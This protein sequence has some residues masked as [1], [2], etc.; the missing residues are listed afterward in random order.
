ML[1]SSNT[2][3]QTST[4]QNGGSNGR[5]TSNVRQRSLVNSRTSRRDSNGRSSPT[6]QVARRDDPIAR[7]G[8]VMAASEI[9]F[10]VDESPEGGFEESTRPPIIRLHLVRDVVIPV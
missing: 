9:V 8:D 7:I 6:L 10:V 2:E 1:M 3:R 4:N 5:G